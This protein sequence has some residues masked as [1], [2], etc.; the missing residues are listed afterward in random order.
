MTKLDFTSI[1]TLSTMHWTCEVAAKS[2]EIWEHLY[3]T[4]EVVNFDCILEYLG[5]Y[6]VHI[7]YLTVHKVGAISND[8][9]ISPVLSDIV[10]CC[11]CLKYLTLESSPLVNIDFR[12]YDEL[13]KRLDTLKLRNVT[14]FPNTIA[15]KNRLNSKC[16]TRMISHFTNLRHIEII[17]TSNVTAGHVMRILRAMPQVIHVNVQGSVI[18][19]PSFVIKVM[20]VCHA[21]QVLKFS[22][23]Q[24]LTTKNREISMRKWFHL[25]RMYYPWVT[26]SETLTCEIRGYLST[27][28]NK[29]N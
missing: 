27:R 20:S 5:K 3:L 15:N 25:T 28:K 18:V 14:V 11:F 26:F 12:V 2:K 9:C 23:K 29:M 24:F 16:F 13:A 4:G 1:H 7:K 19:E 17:N 6:S 10:N 21:V 22:H 8:H